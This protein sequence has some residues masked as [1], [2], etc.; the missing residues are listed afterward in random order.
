MKTVCTI[1]YTDSVPVYV[2]NVGREHLDLTVTAEDAMD[3]YNPVNADELM[4]ECSVISQLGLRYTAK[5]EW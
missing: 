3:F 4:S 2:K 1:D 5:E